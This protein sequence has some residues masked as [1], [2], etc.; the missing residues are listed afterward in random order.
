MG[1]MLKSRHYEFHS[2]NDFL[3]KG[4]SKQVQSSA[5]NAMK[6]K[7]TPMDI[8]KLLIGKTIHKGEIEISS[9]S[10]F[11]CV[12]SLLFEKPGLGSTNE[13]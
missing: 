2:E 1:F 7:L 10:S 4:F 13:R 5:P 9:N 3:D 6:I 8:A 12:M 11:L